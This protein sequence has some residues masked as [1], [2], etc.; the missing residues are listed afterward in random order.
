MDVVFAVLVAVAVAFVGTP[1]AFQATSTFKWSELDGAQR[2][3]IVRSMLSAGTLFGVVALVHAGVL[4]AVTQSPIITVVGS[5]LITAALCG[6][7]IKSASPLK[8][9]AALSKQL[10]EPARRAEARLALLELGTKLPLGDAVNDAIRVSVG[11]ALSNGRCHPEAGAV[12]A[13]LDDSKF[14]AHERE[15]LMLT[16]LSVLVY[17]GELSRAR[18]LLARLPPIAEG[19]TH[20]Y[21]RRFSEAMLLVKESMADAALPLL[22]TPSQ[23]PVIERNRHVVL[24]H[25][26]AAREDEAQLE[27]ALSWLEAQHG[28]SS[29]ERVIEPEGPATAR[30]WARLAGA[31]GPY[32]R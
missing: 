5:S 17:A 4:A 14:E 3:K 31:E 15:L 6:W 18:D 32:R 13:P 30:A 9:V 27:R 19:T 24:A 29:L 1:L 7:S 25:I 16:Q 12:V 10:D 22:A 23:E 26:H 8:R 11:V 2:K 21:A 28:K 20:D